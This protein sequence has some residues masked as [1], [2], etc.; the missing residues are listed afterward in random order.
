MV[1]KGGIYMTD[2]KTNELLEKILN[3]LDEI[4]SE[5]DYTYNCKSELED[6]NKKLEE[7]ESRL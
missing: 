3:K 7:I 2:N 5:V 6:I 1:I 4:N